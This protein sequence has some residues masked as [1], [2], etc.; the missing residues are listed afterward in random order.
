MRRL[1]LELTQ[2][3]LRALLVD[4]T[5]T[6]PRIRQW[7]SEPL[8]VQPTGEVLR[9]ALGNLRSGAAEV[10][11]VIPREQVLTRL[12][13]FPSTQ[14]EELAQMVELSGKAQ[15]PYP[16]D[17]A[18]AD[19]HVVEQQAGSST[20]Q[21]VACHRELLERHVRLL[22]E[23][24][25]EPA[26]I[27]PSSWGL[28]AW[29][30]RIGQA[31][32]VHEPTMVVHVDEDRTD[33][34]LIRQGCLLFS[35]SLAQG[36]K[37]WQAGTEALELL[38]QELER[39][40][41]S[42]RKELPRVE[43]NSFVVTGAGP[44][45]Q[46]QELL[47]TRLGKP[48]LARSASG[49]LRLP[50]SAVNTAGFPAVVIGLAMAERQ[51]LVNLLPREVREAHRHRRRIR[52]LTLTGSLLLATCL[53]GAGLLSVHVNRRQR[54]AQETLN[55]LKS[56]EATTRQLERK[57]RVV[58][59]IE[60]LQASRRLT[61]AMFGELIRLTPPEVLFENL[62]FERSRGELVV[63]GSAQTTRQVLDYI[64]LLDR[65]N[66]WEHVELRY[67]SRRVTSAGDRTDFEIVLLK[68]A[69]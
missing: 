24:G 33:L 35:R 5:L 36:A 3:S 39:T 22:R 7:V 29:Y 68:H 44:I 61:A 48:V 51:W 47:T 17:Q 66:L 13:T 26:W 1:V 16:R 67:S 27:V 28:L 31:Q 53:L 10:I 58:H 15:L 42:L 11:S 64:H 63:R 6:Q 32:D 57:E 38:A 40:T 65:S 62:A 8:S 18:V 56:H 25:L 23:A 2:R 46:W 4:G 60:R 37:D 9:R 55:T 50:E 34:A 20:V 43:I 69:P 30:R 49:D 21:L 52:E 54:T 41:S 14:A 59:L 19:F 45:D 12:M